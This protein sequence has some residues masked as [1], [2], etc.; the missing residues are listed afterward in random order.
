MQGPDIQ[1]IIL[2]KAQH[3]RDGQLDDHQGKQKENGNLING[4]PDRFLP[5]GGM[6]DKMADAHKGLD[7][8]HHS[9][10]C[11]KNESLQ[12]HPD[13][14]LRVPAGQISQ[15]V[16]GLSAQHAEQ[17]SDRGR[18]HQK[19]LVLFQRVQQRRDQHQPHH[20]IKPARQIQPAGSVSEIIDDRQNQQAQHG[21]NHG[22]PFVQE[23]ALVP[24]AQG[25]FF[26]GHG[27]PL[28]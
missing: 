6:D 16:L 1:H 7:K 2:F 15:R 19:Q 22:S 23:K 28:F 18:L 21:C 17:Q 20:Q 12:S 25:K 8:Q 26:S 10:P 5:S 11:Q 4:H 14:G 13:I 27:V 3:R 9:F 24:P